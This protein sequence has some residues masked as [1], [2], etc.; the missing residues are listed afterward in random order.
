MMEI[1]GKRILM[2][3]P[4]GA[5]KHYGDAIKAELEKRSA[6]VY[7]YDERPSQSSYMKIA[8]RLLKKRLPYLFLSYINT[9]IKSNRGVNFDYIFVCRGEAFTPLVVARLREAFPNAKMILYLWD[10]LRT[11]N[12]SE[13]IPYFD[14]AYSF[15]PDDVASNDKLSFRPTFY[16]PQYAEITQNTIYHYDVMFVGTLHSNRYRIIQNFIS[17]FRNLGL[18]FYVYLYV[19]SRIVYIKDWIKKFPYIEFSRVKFIPFTMLDT[20]KILSE[21]K[22]VLD[23]NYT[24]QK[25]L[26]MR[27]FEALAAQRKYITTN[28]E[29]RNY[30]FYDERNILIIDL[31]HPIIPRIFIE[32]PF[33]P[34]S[35]SILYKYS[36]AG[37]V[38]DLF[39]NI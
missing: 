10:I 27:A 17:V 28:P 18:S 37:L 24:S 21:T 9:I 5:T 31:T 29:I 36:V 6:H 39:N 33:Y 11:T 2:F 22:A 7:A 26:S 1:A 3:Y 8:I 25:S 34:I 32:T 13:V 14:K 4:Y 23:I 16:V 12:V 38:D 19:P 30:D 35:D 15:D 20:V